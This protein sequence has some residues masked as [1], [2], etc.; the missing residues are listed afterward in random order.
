[1]LKWKDEKGQE[2]QF[3]LVNEVSSKWYDFGMLLGFSLNQLDVWNTQHAADANKCWIRVMDQW[4]SKG[5]S[6]DYPATWVGLCSLLKDMG[7]SNI[8][9][10]L[11]NYCNCI[12]HS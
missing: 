12:M 6:L 7:F 1:M 10:K 9:Q 11:K 3:S 4:L 8:A 5:G 2:Q